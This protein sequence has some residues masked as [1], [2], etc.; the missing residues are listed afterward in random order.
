MDD[1][2]EKVLKTPFI[3]CIYSV[4]EA[5]ELDNCDCATFVARF[6]SRLKTSVRLSFENSQDNHL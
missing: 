2:R 5:R 1:L 6:L 3:E 4:L